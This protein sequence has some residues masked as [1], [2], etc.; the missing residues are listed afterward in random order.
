MPKPIV[1]L[2]TF[3]EFY[4][5]TV[6]PVTDIIVWPKNFK[7]HTIDFS[8]LCF[9]LPGNLIWRRKVLT[10]CEWWMRFFIIFVSFSSLC[11]QRLSDYQFSEQLYEFQ[12]S[13]G[14]KFQVLRDSHCYTDQTS[15]VHS[16]MFHR[17][18][19]CMIIF[20]LLS[21]IILNFSRTIST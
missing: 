13:P 4:S 15:R 20:S 16:L 12:W 8:S 18:R 10:A 9:P 5:R 1:T 3:Q 21:G 19:S 7:V 17:E 6:K 11:C 14:R 2:H